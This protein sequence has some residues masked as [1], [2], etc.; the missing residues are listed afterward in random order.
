VSVTRFAIVIDCCVFRVCIPFVS[1]VLL[2]WQ[3]A[4]DSQHRK[5]A[6]T[7][8]IWRRVWAWTVNRRVLTTMYQH[9]ANLTTLYVTR[10]LLRT[11]VHQW[12]ISMVKHASK[13]DTSVN[14]LTSP[15]SRSLPMMTL[16]P[17]DVLIQTVPAATPSRGSTAGLDDRVDASRV[18]LD[19]DRPPG[20]SSVPVP[21]LSLAQHRL[22]L[23][24]HKQ[25]HQPLRVSFRRW[26]F[27]VLGLLTADAV[28]F[29]VRECAM[30]CANLGEGKV[31]L[32]SA[33]GF[34]LLEM[35]CAACIVADFGSVVSLLDAKV[36][37][38]R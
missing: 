25:I 9:L 36:V 21:S 7:W 33:R 29:R 10:A 11:A 32:E 15:V 22:R 4:S 23:W 26:R 1:G 5:V 6:S 28:S 13:T 30:C 14:L 2:L 12:R 31:C 38:C 37:A 17:V 27:T 16:L 34:C 19:F 8:K 35:T 18:R 20:P 3:I 24:L